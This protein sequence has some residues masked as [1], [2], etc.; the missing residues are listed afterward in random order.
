MLLPNVTEQFNLTP[1]RKR[2]RCHLM[3]ANSSSPDPLRSRI[4]REGLNPNMDAPPIPVD[5][6][7]PWIG[8]ALPRVEDAALLTG[9]GRY[10]GDTA[11]PPGTLHAAIL[12]S[13]HGHATAAAIDTAKAAA[14]PGVTAILTGT[15]IKALTSSLVVGV[16][17]PVECRPIATTASAMSASPSPSSWQ[18]TA[19]SP[20][21]LST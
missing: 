16:K 13:P 19:T 10:F 1:Q 21:T 18:K 11:T 3:V 14:L 4:A 5:Q 20:T 12:R 2:E 6:P 17:A 15:D 7:A 9:R 8:R